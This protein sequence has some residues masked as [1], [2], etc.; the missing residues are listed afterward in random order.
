MA[1]SFCHCAA[2]SLFMNLYAV[3]SAVLVY[4]NLVVKL[5]PFY[6][7]V[8]K[9]CM[10]CSILCLSMRKTPAFILFSWIGCLSLTLGTLALRNSMIL[11]I[12]N[13]NSRTNEHVFLT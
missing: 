10:D 4:G 2:S 9:S 12:L 5:S 6:Y 8:R 13:I 11:S 1:L 3:S 7:W